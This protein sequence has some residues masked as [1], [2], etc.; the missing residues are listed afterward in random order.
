MVET[1]QEDESGQLKRDVPD[2]VEACKLRFSRGFEPTE[3]TEGPRPTE[4]TEGLE[5]I[6][7]TEATEGPRPTEVTEGLIK[8]SMENP[9]SPN[10]DTRMVASSR[11]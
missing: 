2:Q 11:G 8:I 1:P 4:V 9:Q 5:P 7:P 10:S 6:E 3:A